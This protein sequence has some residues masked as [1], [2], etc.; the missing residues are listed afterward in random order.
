MTL[1]DKVLSLKNIC[2]NQIVCYI[3]NLNQLCDDDKTS[4]S[5]AISIKSYSDFGI[6]S[7]I[8]LDCCCKTYYSKL[9]D[10]ILSYILPQNNTTLCFNS[11][12]QI[13]AKVFVEFQKR[14]VTIQILYY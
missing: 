2:T 1:D 14:Y 6:Y 9:N 4:D 7:K 5:L 11:A 12:K 13:S 3:L 8:I 10:K